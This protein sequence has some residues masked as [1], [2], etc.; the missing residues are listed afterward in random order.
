MA[1]RSLIAHMITMEV[2]KWK[3]QAADELMLQYCSEKDFNLLKF[4]FACGLGCFFTD[5]AAGCSDP[6]WCLGQTHHTTCFGLQIQVVHMK[7]SRNLSTQIPE[8]GS[9]QNILHVMDHFYLG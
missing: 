4:V 7:Q 5:T 8:S 2:Q 3:T 6:G 9:L 1:Q